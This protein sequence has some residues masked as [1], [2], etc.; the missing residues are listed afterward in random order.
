MYSSLKAVELLS[1]KQSGLPLD[2]ILYG[3]CK[4][5]YLLFFEVGYNKNIF[6]DTNCISNFFLI[7]IG[8][9]GLR[10]FH[11]CHMYLGVYG[12]L[13]QPVLSLA[14]KMVQVK[15]LRYLTHWDIVDTHVSSISNVCFYS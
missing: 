10:S 11:R 7:V 1:G 14:L 13:V 5:I 4:T 15:N 8:E 12:R 6:H 2:R 3:I 9:L